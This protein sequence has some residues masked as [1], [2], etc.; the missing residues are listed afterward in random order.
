[1]HGRRDGLLR[2]FAC[3]REL[4][5]TMMEGMGDHHEHSSPNV[6]RYQHGHMALPP[7]YEGLDRPIIIALLYE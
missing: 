6:A 7:E 5:F 3:C 2:Q 1:M 4:G